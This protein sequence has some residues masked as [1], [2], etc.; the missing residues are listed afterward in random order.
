MRPTTW[1]NVTA[2]SMLSRVIAIPPAPSIIV[3]ATSFDAMIG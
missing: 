1:R 2:S 3:A